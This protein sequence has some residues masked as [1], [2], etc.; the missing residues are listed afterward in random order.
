MYFKEDDEN[1]CSL[2]RIYNL[3][4][5]VVNGSDLFDIQ[6][7]GSYSDEDLEPD[8][9]FEET[10]SYKRFVEDLR[11]MSQKWDNDWK[12]EG[13]WTDW[14]SVHAKYVPKMVIECVTASPGQNEIEGYLER[15][16]FQ[17]IGPFRKL[18]HEVSQLS[19]WAM[20]GEDFCEAIGYVCKYD[21]R[22][23]EVTACA[24]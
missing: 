3:G 5:F 23:N 6:S 8:A 19:F 15:L 12:N 13:S 11:G 21:E 1:I 18:K 20:S 22:K 10:S 14:N 7:G 16:G 9:E 24:A 2:L 17:R 4:G